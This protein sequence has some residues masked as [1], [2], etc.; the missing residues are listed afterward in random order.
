MK[1]G[2]SFDYMEKNNIVYKKLLKDGKVNP[3]YR[4]FISYPKNMKIFEHPFLSWDNLSYFCDEPDEEG[5]DDYLLNH[6]LQEGKKT[7]ISV[8]TKKA[9]EIKEVFGKEYLI[10]EIPFEN[11]FS[12]VYVCRKGS[13]IDYFDEDALYEY[14]DQSGVHFNDGVLTILLNTP[15]I[16]IA[17][18]KINFRNNVVYSPIMR[19]D[20]SDGISVTYGGAAGLVSGLLFGYPVESSISMIENNVFGFE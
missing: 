12:R 16:D 18:G 13:L 15:M 19:M 9:D 10:H 1:K 2:F 14:Y 5:L 6:A 3:D 4:M 17:S 8:V 20:G 7:S 11:G